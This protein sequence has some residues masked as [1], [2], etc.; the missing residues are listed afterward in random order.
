[1]TPPATPPPPQDESSPGSRDGDPLPLWRIGALGLAFLALAT[2]LLI[3]SDL[4]ASPSA[5]ALEVQSSFSQPSFDP[6]QTAV[7]HVADSSL[8]TLFSCAAT[9]VDADPAG[10]TWFAESTYWNIF[11]GEPAPSAFQGHGPNCAFVSTSATPLEDTPDLGGQPSQ[12]IVN[13]VETSI[14]VF[15][16][17]G[18]FAGDAT[19]NID[20]KSTSTVEIPFYFHAQNSYAPAA[21]RVRVTSVADP[22]GEWAALSEVASTTDSAAAVRS[23]VFRGSVELRADADA[24]EGDGVVRVDGVGDVVQLTYYGPSGQ[25]AVS[26]ASAQVGGLPPSPTPT[27]T[28]TATPLPDIAFSRPSFLPG[29]R[30]VFYVTDRGLNNLSSCTVKMGRRRA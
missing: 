19:L 10:V 4:L 23:G 5:Q 6:D 22:V 24:T 16:A 25:T 13:G 14:E 18:E 28:P 26:A 15:E 11:S 20:V 12:A 1:M 21:Q 29:Q 2:F 7:F 3:S 30:A 9:W 8:D 17:E 27:P